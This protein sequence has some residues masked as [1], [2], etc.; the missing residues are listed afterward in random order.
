[1]GSKFALLVVVLA[2][3]AQAEPLVGKG[4]GDADALVSEATKLYNK[5][6][7]AKAADLFTKATRSN[8][9]PLSPYL[10]LSRS[11]LAAKQVQRA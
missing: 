7:Y 3:T 2:V 6:Q 11:L 1:M 4:V 9:A 5:K 8:P 10:Q